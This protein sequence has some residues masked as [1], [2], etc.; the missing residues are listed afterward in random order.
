MKS[1]RV[2]IVGAGPA[3]SAA[4]IAL[5]NRRSVE[6][7][8]LEAQTFPR[9]K[10]CGSGLSPW[11]LDELDAI[12]IGRAVRREAFPIRGARVAGS[13]GPIVELRGSAEAAVLLRE[14][15]DDL[16][17]REAAAR[18]ADLRQGVRATSIVRDGGRLL[19][20]ETSA[21]KL[22]ADALIVASGAQSRLTEAFRKGPRLHTVMAWFEG[23]E[24]VREQVELYFDGSVKPYYGW[25]FPESG[26]H[27]NIGICY[28]QGERGPNAL[29]RFAAFREHRLSGRLRR[30]T[31]IGRF[32]GHPILTSG[33]VQR[34]SEAATLVAGEAG[35]LVDPATAEGIYHAL[36]SG[37]TAGEF[38]GDL[39]T[40]NRALTPEALAPYTGL[41]RQRIGARLRAGDWLL[42]AA[43]T[44][45]LDFALRLGSWR[46]IQA[47]LSW[48][49][50]T[51]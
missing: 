24:D 18:G 38:L 28:A 20:L 37:R 11:C 3:G 33:R 13:R 26:R 9:R 15:F 7:V 31:Q 1:K 46:P 32:V 8:L 29:E 44:P 14:R 16:L 48:A 17:A 51:A 22:E 19:G 45:I 41:V 27:V 42:T 6:T 40:E 2:V 10:P 34:L 5:S 25:L 49:L 4:A 35:H 50:T 23:V 30:A 43:K 36:V 12:G 39:L 21:G 47:A